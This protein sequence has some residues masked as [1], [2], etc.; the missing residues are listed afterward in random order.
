[1]PRR[2]RPTTTRQARKAT[3]ATTTHHP[4]TVNGYTYCER[5]GIDPN[6]PA[7]SVISCR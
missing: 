7:A 5:C 4:R 6:H 1:M 2:N 3:T